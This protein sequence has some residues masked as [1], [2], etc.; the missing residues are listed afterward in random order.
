M[1]GNQKAKITFLP[2]ANGDGIL[3]T[4][5]GYSMLI[6]GG[7]SNTYKVLKQ[8]LV[9][10]QIKTVDLAILTHSDSDHIGGMIS[11][12]KDSNF[13]IRNI[14]FNSYDKLSQIFNSGYKDITK[15]ITILTLWSLCFL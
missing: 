2:V 8:H 12:I 4:L 3:L 9:T 11:L 1:N 10:N 7:F 14:W 6:D 5:D 13:H 15:D